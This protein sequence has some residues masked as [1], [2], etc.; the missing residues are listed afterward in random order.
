MTRP[1]CP[2]DVPS[3]VAT[4]FDRL[5]ELLGS[6]GAPEDAYLLLLFAEA[7]T[8]WRSAQHQVAE[9]GSVVMSGGAAIPHP[10]L[11]VAAQAHGQIVALARELG[12]SPAARAKLARGKKAATEKDTSPLPRVRLHRAAK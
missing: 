6:R 7:W 9:Q 1:A 11:S 2:A 12:F 8:T 4:E 3:E 10:A 5:A